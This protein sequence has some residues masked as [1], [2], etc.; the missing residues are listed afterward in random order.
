MTV[1]IGEVPVGVISRDNLIRNRRATRRPQDLVN[2]D[3]PERHGE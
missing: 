1:T 2:A 3:R